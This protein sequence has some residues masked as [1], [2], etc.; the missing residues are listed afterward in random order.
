MVS[1]SRKTAVARVKVLPGTGA[2][3]VNSKALNVYFRTDSLR[4]KAL[5]PLVALSKQHE[6]DVKASVKGG[7]IT[8][9]AEAL[10]HAIARFLAADNEDFKAVLNKEKLTT[11]DPR[12]VERKKYGQRKARRRFQWVKR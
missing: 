4:A 1:G 12:M 8:G 9:Q 5:K 11:R 3:I 6:Y 7:G 10:S 2:F